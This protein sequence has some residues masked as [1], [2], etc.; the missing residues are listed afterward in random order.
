MAK[1]GTNDHLVIKV[2]K[3][4]IEERLYTYGIDHTWFSEEKLRQTLASVLREDSEDYYQLHVQKLCKLSSEEA[5]RLERLK[6][7]DLQAVWKKVEELWPPSVYI[8]DF[9]K[10][11]NAYI[12]CKSWSP[13]QDKHCEK[14]PKQCKKDIKQ[15][16]R[17]IKQCKRDIKQSEKDIDI[18]KQHVKAYKQCVKAHNTILKDLYEVEDESLD[19]ITRLLSLC[20]W[21]YFFYTKKKEEGHNAY[22]STSHAFHSDLVICFIAL[23]CRFTPVAEDIKFSELPQLEHIIIHYGIFP[24]HPAFQRLV[25]QEMLKIIIPGCTVNNLQQQDAVAM[26]EYIYWCMS[27]GGFS[28]S[29]KGLDAILLIIS[30]QSRYM[31]LRQ[32]HLERNYV[33]DKTRRVLSA[34]TKILSRYDFIRPMTDLRDDTDKVLKLFNHC[35]KEAHRTASWD[36]ESIFPPFTKLDGK[37][38]KTLNFLHHLIL[39]EVCRGIPGYHCPPID[40]YGWLK[41]QDFIKEVRKLASTVVKLAIETKQ[42]DRP[43][44]LYPVIADLAVALQLIIA[45]RWYISEV[46]QHKKVLFTANRDLIN[47][48]EVFFIFLAF[49]AIMMYILVQN[50]HPYGVQRVAVKLPMYAEKLRFFLPLVFLEKSDHIV[51]VSPCASIL[52]YTKLVIRI[53]V[54]IISIYFGIQGNHD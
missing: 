3:E 25:L 13:K 31:A 37:S 12:L 17:D 48:Q 10:T 46:E 16:K 9:T 32:P 22:N 7:Q 39:I 5:V 1:Q 26:A 52:S 6:E 21:A 36:D 23:Q 49:R 30:D 11:T 51:S 24:K 4:S 41:L 54:I 8:P 40:E 19:R 20:L 15:C 27:P 47:H 33:A 44:V 34:A 38:R 35:I 18:I 42:N 53:L 50:P 29:R 45:A 28:W 2:V 14:A 43:R